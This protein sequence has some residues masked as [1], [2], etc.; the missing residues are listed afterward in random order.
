MTYAPIRVGHFFAGGGGGILASEILGHQ[1][2][3]ATDV[4]ERRCRVVEESGWFPGI[5]V[6]CVDVREFDP[7]P[8]EGRMDCVAGCWRGLE[9]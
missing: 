3:L 1:S 5:H 2:V 6:E 7:R 8:W 9:E 4:D